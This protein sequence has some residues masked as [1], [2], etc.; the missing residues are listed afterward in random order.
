VASELQV[1]SHPFGLTVRPP[2][3]S[4]TVVLYLHGDRHL[5][6][7]PESALDLAGHLAL[8]TGAEVVCARYRS[9]FPAALEDVQAAYDFCQ[10]SGGPVVVAGKRVGAGLAASL[11]VR[12][13]D[14][15]A[16]PPEC[17]ILVSALL[18]LTMDAP[19]LLF[20]AGA[21]PTFDVAELRRRVADYADGTPPSDALLS[22]LFA[23]LHGLPPVQLQIAGADPLLDDSLA[24]AA[25]AAHS[26]VTVDLH[27]RP[28]GAALRAGTVAAAASFMSARTPATCPAPRQPLT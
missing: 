16:R 19:S 17:A 12:L 10:A 7:A 27:V 6:S 22:P 14:Q 3:P 20:N 26:G 18:D 9:T 4:P 25:R 2:D 11:L 28:D 5:S 13:R 21:D 15:G 23:N 24:F 1:E 8:R